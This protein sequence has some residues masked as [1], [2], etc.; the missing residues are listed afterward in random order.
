M[1]AAFQTIGGSQ[2]WQQNATRL[3]T[4][5]QHCL[6]EIGCFGDRLGDNSIPAGQGYPAKKSSYLQISRDVCSRQHSKSRITPSYANRAYTW[7]SVGIFVGIYEWPTMKT[8]TGPT[9]MNSVGD[10]RTSQ[11]SPASP[12]EPRHAWLC[13]VFCCGLPPATSSRNNRRFRVGPSG[14]LRNARALRAAFFDQVFRL[15]PKVL[16]NRRRVT[17]M[18]RLLDRNQGNTRISERTQAM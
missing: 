6:R 5:L 9:D 7:M 13:G 1:R 11:V 10:Q 17:N 4:P 18:D 14:A 15:L 12:Q 16:S 2:C 3:A 8:S